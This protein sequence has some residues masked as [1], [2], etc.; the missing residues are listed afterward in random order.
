MVKL[1]TCFDGAW[2]LTQNIDVAS[3]QN[4]P[5]KHYVEYGWREGRW[6]NLIF[7]PLWYTQNISDVAQLGMEPLQ[8]FER[9]GRFEGRRPSATFDPSAHLRLH[10]DVAESGIEPCEHYLRYGN[11][12]GRTTFETAEVQVPTGPL[13][14]DSEEAMP[15]ISAIISAMRDAT[16]R[17]GRVLAEE[18]IIEAVRVLKA[19]D[20]ARSEWR[21]RLLA[22]IIYRVD[23]DHRPVPDGSSYEY[24]VLANALNDGLLS[25]GV[26]S[27]DDLI[28]QAG[29]DPVGAVEALMQ[30]ELGD[31][32]KF[33]FRLLKCFGGEAVS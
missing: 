18:V 24:I 1:S 5:F 29:I 11:S 26:P 7:D 16:A 15:H 10:A 27:Y 17:P 12:E 6:P 32:A 30:R 19:S 13:P 2:Y 33:Q 20:E 14:P 8:H 9:H 21:S 3:K 31:A 23:E 25:N 22:N 4:D 28:S